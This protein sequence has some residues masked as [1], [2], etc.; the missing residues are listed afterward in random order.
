MLIEKKDIE[1]VYVLELELIDD[2]RGSFARTFCVDEFI[3]AGLCANWVQHNISYNN[4][5]GVLRGIHYQ[6]PPFSEEKVVRCVRGSI[7]D[8]VL[9]LRPDSSTYCQWISEMLTADSGRALYIPQGCAHGFQALEDDSDVYYLMSEKYQ[10]DYA[11]GVRWDDPAFCI[12][13]LE[14]GNMI[15]SQKDNNF[16]D[17]KP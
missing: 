10:P 1:G 11:A 4:R 13:W 15:M 16:P 12:D 2:E 8:V 6:K 5:K 3:A 9:D 14:T 17:F 7:Y